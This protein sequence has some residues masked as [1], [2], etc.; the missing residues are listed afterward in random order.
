MKSNFEPS[1]SG[2]SLKFLVYPLS[3]KAV[4][5]NCNCCT[6]SLSLATSRLTHKKDA[7]GAKDALTRWGKSRFLVVVHIAL[8][9][10]D[11]LCC[12]CKDLLSAESERA[13]P[14]T[15]LRDQLPEESYSTGHLL[16]LASALFPAKFSL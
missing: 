5:N 7:A 10:Y 11:M 3:I 1:N 2:P 6:H 9:I 13:T 15:Q 4:Q 14:S 16:E 12:S 8:C